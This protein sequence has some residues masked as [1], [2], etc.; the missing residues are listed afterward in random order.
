[1]YPPEYYLERDPEKI[2][3][4]METV[5]FA[6][7]ISRTEDDIIVTHIPLILDRHRGKSG[8]LIGHMDRNNPHTTYLSDAKVLVI[9]QGPNAYISPNVFESSQLP[10]WNYIAV[11]VKGRMVITESADA[12][13]DS[14]IKMAGI[15]ETGPNPYVLDKANA[16]MQH[17]INHVIGFEIEILEMTG[18]F[19]LSQNKHSVDRLLARETLLAE[20]NRIQEALIKSV[21]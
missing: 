2:Y 10:T 16:K 18:R 6:T 15:L 14:M 8:V 5:R 13:M 19:K 3:R 7:M 4:V 11:H 1:M 9:F 17:L 12:V 20:S 21:F